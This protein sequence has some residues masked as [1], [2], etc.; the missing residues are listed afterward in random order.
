[1]TTA[2]E[3]SSTTV[4]ANTWHTSDTPTL[5]VTLSGAPSED[6]FIIAYGRQNTSASVTLPAG[7]TMIAEQ[8]LSG[9]SFFV[10]YKI[11]GAS[12]GSTYGFTT[13]AT[14][15]SNDGFASVA[16]YSGVDTTTPFD[17][18][19]DDHI[20]T[21]STSTSHAPP[22]IGTR[23]TNTRVLSIIF[24]S[25][26]TG[27]PTGYSP[28]TGYTMDESG[29]ANNGP[30][31]AIASKVEAAPGDKDPGDWS[32]TVTSVAT[33][34]T[35]ALRDSA[36]TYI[37]ISDVTWEPPTGYSYVEYNGDVIPQHSFL[38][39]ASG[40]HTGTSG[41][42]LTDST[43]SLIADEW[44][45][46]R[47]KNFND[48]SE[49]IIGSHLS[50][51]GPFTLS[52]ALSGGTDNDFDNGDKYDIEVAM[53]VGDQIGYKLSETSTNGVYPVTFYL[54]DQAD[55][56]VTSDYTG[57]VL[58]SGLAADKTG[59][60]AVRTNGSSSFTI[61]GDAG[62]GSMSAL[63]SQIL[64]TEIFGTF[65]TAGSSSPSAAL[66]GTITS[67]ATE[68]DI[69]TGGD[70]IILTL[71]NDTWVASG[72]TFDAQRQNIIDG[73][74]AASSPTFG[75]NN[76]VRD[77][78][79]VGTVVRT[80]DTV[81]TITLSAQGGYNTTAQ[82]VITATI[83]ASALTSAAPLVASPTFTVDNVPAPA[84]AVTGTA[85]NQLASVIAAG[86]TT[87]IITLTEDTWIAAGTGPIG[88]TAQSQ[89]IIDGIDSNLAE[90]TGWDAE[91]KAN[92]TP[93]TD[94]V[95]T[96]DTVCTITIPSS[97]LSITATETIT[98]TIPAAV[99]V[100]S[101]SPVIA[102]GFTVRSPST[103]G[104]MVTEIKRKKKPKGIDDQMFTDSNFEIDSLDTPGGG[105]TIDEA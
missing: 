8:A 78:I 49:G 33:L 70:T 74:D 73:L 31:G 48:G 87:L 94:M 63:G 92:L 76:E 27:G 40:T 67:S 23:A 47:V 60:V 99:L 65:G 86:G 32:L 51:A 103:G 58:A 101:A 81:V 61:T 3:D 56:S 46:Y 16:V 79:A 90:A 34:I 84:A 85:P 82:E 42:T 83:P 39:K 52:T 7:F 30:A 66:S 15:T 98:T 4:A 71:S 102:P 45:N 91:V 69:R 93:A 105:F 95:R 59:T 21:Y 55:G 88:T 22:D 24:T 10:G 64:G 68:V 57:S 19:Y 13:D 14:I 1:M 41:S 28:P 12:E 97:S 50:G 26:I 53:N 44:E 20:A 6:E 77:K 2:Y 96:S 5:N 75:W 35:L 62:T 72:A 29:G 89:S 104:S 37:E 100:T 25:V 43:K 17:V 11:A 54:I 38:F 80:S 9:N 36:S 18:T